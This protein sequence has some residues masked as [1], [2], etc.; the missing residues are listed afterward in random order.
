MKEGHP[1]GRMSV[2]AVGLRTR[3][4]VSA[5]MTGGLTGTG[6]TDILI[7]TQ[8]VVD[9]S[10]VHYPVDP[11]SC[12]KNVLTSGGQNREFWYRSDSSRC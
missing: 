1:D 11:G 2:I 5:V 7:M 10:L 3:R 8:Q 9:R 4:L 6:W 12:K